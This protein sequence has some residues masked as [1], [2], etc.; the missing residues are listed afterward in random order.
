[1]VVMETVAVV[2]EMGMAVGGAAALAAAGGAVAEGMVVAAADLV[3]EVTD[4]ENG[5]VVVAAMERVSPVGKAT[6]VATEAEV[7]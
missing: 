5:E 4:Q 7:V 3:A 2:V 6:V 1:M